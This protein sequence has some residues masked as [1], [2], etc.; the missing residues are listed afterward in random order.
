MS[1]GD[2]RALFLVG[3]VSTEGGVVGIEGLFVLRREVLVLVTRGDFGDPPGGWGVLG[4]VVDAGG[5]VST[6]GLF[7]FRRDI[8]AL[9]AGEGHDLGDPLGGGRVLGG[10][11]GSTPTTEAHV[12]GPGG[13]TPKKLG[14]G[15]VLKGVPSPDGGCVPGVTGRDVLE[16]VPSCEPDERVLPDLVLS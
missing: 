4:G 11:V 14:S 12:L 10:V 3:M 6:E 9:V 2:G 16:G 8:L 1:L 13:V 5:V 7:V 15:R